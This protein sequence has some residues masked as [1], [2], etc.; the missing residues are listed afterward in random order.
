MHTPPPPLKGNILDVLK[1]INQVNYI[2]FY[3]FI[4]IV[5][6]ALGYVHDQH[7]WPTRHPQWS[8]WGW[9][10][11]ERT[12]FQSYATSSPESHPVPP[13]QI[14]TKHA[15]YSIWQPQSQSLALP[16]AFK[17][18][19]RRWRP[20]ALD[21]HL[22][23]ALHHM[24]WWT[25]PCYIV[26]ALTVTLKCTYHGARAGSSSGLKVQNWNSWVSYLLV[27]WFYL[28]VYPEGGSRMAGS[29]V[30]HSSSACAGH[31]MRSRACQHRYTHQ[32]DEWRP[33]PL[34]RDSMQEGTLRIFSK[35]FTA[36]ANKQ[37][38]RTEDSMQTF[39]SLRQEDSASKAS[40][41][42]R[43][44]SRAAWA[45]KWSPVSKSK[46]SGQW[47]GLDRKMLAT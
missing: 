3:F 14:Y 21:S 8:A 15:L 47:D 31:T 30:V 5:S 19:S 36:I 43:V 41:G 18:A 45:N 29:W 22:E 20:R 39:S 28:W 16:W 6:I 13:K 40:L 38:R 17:E 10:R 11:P 42:Y 9:L 4:N 46:R 37:E 35:V 32:A 12:T 44:S 34:N 33:R 23:L 27:Q 1:L 2:S 24:H 26:P 25:C 7:T